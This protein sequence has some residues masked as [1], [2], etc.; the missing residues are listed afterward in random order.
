VTSWPELPYAAWKDTLATLHMKLQI[1]GKVRLALSPF[2]PEWAN[3][4]LY[5]TARGLT[6]T[7]MAYDGLIFQIDADLIDHQVVI[8][9]VRGESRRVALTAGR[10]RTSTPTSCQL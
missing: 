5:V 1:V 10:S 2:E 3:V 9:T 6:T 4:P 7:P 8:Q